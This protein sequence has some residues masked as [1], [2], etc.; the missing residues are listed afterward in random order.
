MP[1]GAAGV[2]GDAADC[3]RG[4][5]QLALHR[6]CKVAACCVAASQDGSR[7]RDAAQTATN[8]RQ[9]DSAEEDTLRRCAASA[10]SKPPT[11]AAK[12]DSVPEA[13]CLCRVEWMRLWHSPLLAARARCPPRTECVQALCVLRRVPDR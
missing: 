5:A 9:G 13:C 3:H 1:P 2:G 8:C 10:A 11:P 6:R 7:G 12:A 4:R